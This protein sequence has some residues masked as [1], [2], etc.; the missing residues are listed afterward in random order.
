MNR[1]SLQQLSLLLVEDSP[2]DVFLVKEAMKE[3]G[4]SCRVEVADDGEKAMRI[5][6][7]VDAGTE[8]VRDLLLVDLNVPCQSGTEVLERLRRMPRCARTPVVIMSTSDTPVER[9]RALD[10]GATEYFCKPSSLAEFM[11]LGR[12]IRRMLE[13]HSGDAA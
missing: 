1:D 2:A 5:L 12:L 13:E 4:L 7:E 9:K 8:D 11:K 6:E 10:L 3:E